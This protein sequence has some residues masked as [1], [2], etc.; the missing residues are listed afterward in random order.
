MPFDPVTHT[1]LV[2]QKALVQALQTLM[3]GVDTKVDGV[4]TDVNQVKAYTDTLET[5]LGQHTTKL[6]T[7]EGA[8]GGGSGL[9]HLTTFTSSGTFTVPTGVDFVFLFGCAGGQGGGV[10]LINMYA[11]GFASA[12]LSFL[13]AVVAPNSNIPVVI[14]AGGAPSA[15]ET[16]NAGSNTAFGSVLLRNGNSSYRNADNW[17]PNGYGLNE[18]FSY[19]S[20]GRGVRSGDD[21]AG[22][23][24]G[25]NGVL[26][27]FG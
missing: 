13:P 3:G 23:T 2:S 8:M 9:Q 19:G 12:Y 6:N 24:A 11:H 18:T 15:N 4:A 21:P 25:G 5:V 20:G 1:E 26:F 17:S 10:Q 27:I 14:G 16:L 7:I 22:V